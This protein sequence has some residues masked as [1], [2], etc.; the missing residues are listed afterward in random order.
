MM[1]HQRA[2]SSVSPP[3]VPGLEAASDDRASLGGWNSVEGFRMNSPEATSSEVLVLLASGTVGEDENH[4]PGKKRDDVVDSSLLRDVA[5]EGISKLVS[6]RSELPLSSRVV[7]CR[8]EG[9]CRRKSAHV[10]KEGLELTGFLCMVWGSPAR[11]FDEPGK[12]SD[13]W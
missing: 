13:T 1:V 7:K 11:I 10:I 2:F 8:S 5:D 4:P 6:G 9:L 12:T 3:D